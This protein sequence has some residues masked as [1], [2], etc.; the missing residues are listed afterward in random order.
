MAGA[1]HR[2]AG[3][4]LWEECKR[5]GGCETGEAKLTS[6]HRLKARYIIHTV[7]PV[8]SGSPEDSRDLSA[9]YSK[10]LHLADEKGIAS[11]SF[12]A[13]SAGAFGYPVEEAAKVALSTVLD[14]VRKGTNI[15]L[16]RFVLYSESDYEVFRVT[17][18]KL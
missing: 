12:P 4:G 8:Y 7:G 11:I 5:L 2:A 13:I 1:I 16:I 3:P 17:L 14:Y 10:S 6:G 9:C 15:R 18:E